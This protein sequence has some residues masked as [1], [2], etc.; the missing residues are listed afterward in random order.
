MRTYPS[1]FFAAFIGLA[2]CAH[3][4]ETSPKNGPPPPAGGEA[5]Q[6]MFEKFDPLLRLAMQDKSSRTMAALVKL[7]QPLPAS[8][9][10]ELKQRGLEILSARETSLHVRGDTEALLLLARREEVVRLEA[11]KPLRPAGKETP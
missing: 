9:M 8:V 1:L 5:H 3:A 7:T 10:G 4:G 6:D 2:G 11:S